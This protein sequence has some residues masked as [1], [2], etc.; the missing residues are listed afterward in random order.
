MICAICG[1]RIRGTASTDH[2]FP[3][4][5]YKWSECYVSKGEYKRIK[6]QIV[7]SDNLVGTHTSCN[8]IKEDGIPKIECLHI[9]EQQRISLRAVEESLAGVVNRYTCGKKK[10]LFAQKGCCRGCGKE[11][12]GEGVLRRIDP[13]QLREWSN[14]CIV[15]HSCNTDRPD[16]LQTIPESIFPQKPRLT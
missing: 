16:F 4:A 15:C 8:K 14:A 3:R 5:L 1:A 10:I 6:K 9:S 12:K 13:T 2:V 7:G 11:I